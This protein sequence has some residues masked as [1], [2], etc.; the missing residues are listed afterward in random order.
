M[1]ALRWFTLR[2]LAHHPGRALLVVAVV[3]AAVAPLLGVYVEQASVSQAKRNLAEQLA[4]PTPIR[5]VGSTLKGGIDA[6]ELRTVAS[7][8]GVRRAVPVVQAVTVLEG[9]DQPVIALGIDCANAPILTTLRCEPARVA[10]SA[11]ESRPTPGGT[12]RR[13]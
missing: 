6:R 1:N 12:P 8:P 5:V 2:R 7:T 10:V 9:S 11:S 3:A 4:G 13:P